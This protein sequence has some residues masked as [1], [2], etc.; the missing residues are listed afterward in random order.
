VI[1]EADEAAGDKERAL[2]NLRDQVRKGETMGVIEMYEQA[3]RKAGA[4]TEECLQAA[5]AGMRELWR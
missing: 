5:R 3:A 4:T 1:T 2:E